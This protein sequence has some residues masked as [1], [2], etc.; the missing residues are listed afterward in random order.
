MTLSGIYRGLVWLVIA[1]V[2]ALLGS[3]GSATDEGKRAQSEAASTPVQKPVGRSEHLMGDEDDD[4]SS[5]NHDGNAHDADADFD[6]DSE[7][8]ENRAYF[9]SDD[10][11][12]RSEGKQADASDRTAIGAAVASYHSA[13]ATAS[14]AAACTLMPTGMQKSIPEDYGRGAGPAYARGDTCRIVMTKLLKHLTQSSSAPIL[15]TSTR[16]KGSRA[17][18][19]IG[20]RAVPAGYFPLIRENGEWRIDALVPVGLP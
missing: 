7:A 17:W 1:T 8:T 5:G 9:D 10:S 16:V 11:P 19:I 18:A 20:S 14:G 12:L 13:M 4:E 2:V 3:C 6:V 15:V